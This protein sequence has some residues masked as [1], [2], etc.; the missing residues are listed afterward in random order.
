M[1]CA[2]DLE[3]VARQQGKNN[4]WMSA[5]EQEFLFGDIQGL[6]RKLKLFTKQ[7]TKKILYAENTYILKLLRSIFTARIEAFAISGNK[8][9]YACVKGPRHS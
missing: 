5:K 6:F 8:F 2:S 7:E 4:A 1:D 9:L 3:A